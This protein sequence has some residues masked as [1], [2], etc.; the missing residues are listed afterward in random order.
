VLE[1]IR[2]GEVMQ[3][4]PQTVHGDLNLSQVSDIFLQSHHHGLPVIDNQDRLQAVLTLQD[5]E[6]IPV[7]EWEHT[8]A[9]QAGTRD[10]LLAYPDESIGVALRRMGADDVGRLPVVERNDPTHL[11]GLLRRADLVRA[12][13][14]ALARREMMRHRTQQVQLS[15]S[16]TGAEV[17]EFTVRVG[18]PCAGHLVSKIPWPRDC[19]IAS[20]RRGPRTLLPRGK[21]IIQP[22]DVLLV[23]MEP[24]VRE[25]VER[26]CTNVES[27]HLHD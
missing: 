22:G 23:V 14:V 7:E 24:H 19:V 8:T 2:V 5:L 6:K 12:Y 15:A 27:S 20:V 1:T 10:L 3:K 18:A 11:L 16:S 9:L 25:E 4:N 13:D 21:T 26:L 17:V